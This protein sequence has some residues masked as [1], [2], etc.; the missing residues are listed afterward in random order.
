M[1]EA[2][3][4]TLAEDLRAAKALIDTPEKWHQGWY[5][6]GKGAFCALGACR[7]VTHGK[8]GDASPAATALKEALP[9]K[10]PTVVIFNDAADTTHADI[11]ALFDRAIKHLEARV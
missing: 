1:S 5:R 8:G 6:N 9:D 4:P 2:V 10:W 3:V 11:M 7:E